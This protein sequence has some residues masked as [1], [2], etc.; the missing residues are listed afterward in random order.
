MT[1]FLFPVIDMEATGRNIEKHR[2]A[3][4]MKI[5]DVQ[6]LF[7]FSSPQAIYK[8]ERGKSLPSLDNLVALACIFECRVEDLLVMKS[9][10]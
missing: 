8:W 7:G 10:G 4:G 5:R 1:V 6:E 2:R 9:R 3:S